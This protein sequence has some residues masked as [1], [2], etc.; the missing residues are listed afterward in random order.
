MIETE[1]EALVVVRAMMVAS[2][3]LN[4]MLN[5]NT[6]DETKALIQKDLDVMDKI[7]TKLVPDYKD[8]I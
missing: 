6:D 5:N 8:I 1:E 3:V 7:L 2:K 4:D